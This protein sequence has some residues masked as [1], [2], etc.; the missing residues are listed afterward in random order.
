M[1]CEVAAAARNSYFRPRVAHRA[2]R[3]RRMQSAMSRDGRRPDGP[4][5]GGP[6]LAR[7]IVVEFP[8]IGPVPFCG[9]VLADMGAEV[10]RIDRVAA[11]DLGIAMPSRYNLLSRGKR[12]IALDLKHPDGV[13]IAHRL[14]GQAQILL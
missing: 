8:A 14:V 1:M 7:V 4:R 12:S 13:A 10:I 9:M 11:S 3:S 2:G 6:P 5:N